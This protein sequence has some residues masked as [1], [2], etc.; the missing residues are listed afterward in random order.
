MTL[1][2]HRERALKI[3]EIVGERNPAQSSLLADEIENHLREVTEIPGEWFCPKCFYRFHQ[4]TLNAHTLQVGI[5]SSH[6]EPDPCPNDGES[7]QPLSWRQDAEE[8]NRA[9]LDLLK[10]NR[11]LQERLD[12][13]EPSH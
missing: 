2:T 7:L 10:Q 4:R 13:L 12:E 1:P 11:R 3:L 5:S 9:A 6:S 8:A